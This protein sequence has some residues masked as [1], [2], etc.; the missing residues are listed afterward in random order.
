MDHQRR[1]LLVGSVLGFAAVLPGIG[2]AAAELTLTPRQTRGPFYPTRIPL[3]SDNDLVI[4][5]GKAGEAKG[6]IANVVGQVLDERGKAIDGARIEIWQCDANGRYHHPW[7]TRDA[8]LDLNFQGYGEFTTGADGAYRFRTIKPVPY[9]GRAPHI[10][11]AVSVPGTQ[12]LVTQMYV[13]GAPEN[14]RDWILNSIRDVRARQSLIVS[15]KRHANFPGEL[16]GNFDIVLAADG[17][18]SEA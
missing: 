17:R 15:F 10:H 1:R 12:P 16:M 2:S 8:P 6:E 3:D 9:P 11:F 7:D 5:N 14:K 4:V 18:L 13:A